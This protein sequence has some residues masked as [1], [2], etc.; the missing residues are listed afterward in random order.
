MLNPDPDVKQPVG[1]SEVAMH[2]FEISSSVVPG[3]PWLVQVLERYWLLLQPV[4]SEVNRKWAVI[5]KT[6]EAEVTRLQPQTDETPAK[7][8]TKTA[9]VNSPEIEGI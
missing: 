1:R 3:Y 8:K 2:T 7:G 6:K 4:T 9:Q 5:N